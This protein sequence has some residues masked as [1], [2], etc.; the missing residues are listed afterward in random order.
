MGG[1]GGVMP[2]GTVGGTPGGGTIGTIGLPG[3]VCTHDD[4]SKNMN[5]SAFSWGVMS[6][7]AEHPVGNGLSGF[8]MPPPAPTWTSVK[9]ARPHCASAVASTGV[10]N[11]RYCTDVAEAGLL[12]GA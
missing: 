1:G 7:D 2:G 12:A 3:V 4:R 8:D 9:T 10:L 5:S 11:D 6:S